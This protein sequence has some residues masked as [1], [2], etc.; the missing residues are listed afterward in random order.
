MTDDLDFEL[1]LHR[2]ADGVDMPRGDVGE[3]VSRA[4]R[5]TS[6]RRRALVA[7]ITVLVVAV[8]AT[9]VE[10][11]G[12]D[13]R[14]AGQSIALGAVSAHLGDTGIQWQRVNP[15]SALGF[16]TDP[17]GTSALYAL[18]TSPGQADTGAAPRVVW[19]SEDGVDWTAVGSSL[20]NDLY[21]SDL[22]SADQRIYAVGT[23][24]AT[25]S[26]TSG[27]A[28]SGAL[29]VGWSD[30]NA[31]TFAKHAL[32]LDLASIARY[33]TSVSMNQTQV[34]VG[35]H[36]AVVAATVIVDPDVAALLPSG[37][38][39]PNGWVITR[40]G[41]DLLGNGNAC[42]AGT[43][44][45]PKKV[46]LPTTTIA[47]D[48]AVGS[49]TETTSPAPSQ[50]E[51]AKKLRAEK[52]AVDALGNPAGNAS[53]GRVYRYSCYSADGSEHLTNPQA[54]RGVT[55]SFT[56]AQLG[57]D[58]DLLRAIRGEPFVFAAAGPGSTDFHRVDVAGIGGV[59]TMVLRADDDGFDLV[60]TSAAD[61]VSPKSESAK[62]V[63]LHSVDG[64][65]WTANDAAPQGI[66]W[67]SAVGSI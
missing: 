49:S 2:L 52:A 20:G 24:P 48:G 27:D 15:R 44:E 40:D 67:V 12:R 13:G 28:V 35:A 25:A 42:P 26:T 43:T 11:A 10:I 9:G 58:G 1:D 30:D 55:R 64:Q 32:P 63:V 5:R 45:V 62:L 51:L 65:A 37:V 47:P 4:A 61:G 8:A 33:A 54:T 38:T 3:V 66:D 21:L 60:A 6:H 41:V 29:L 7:G 23:G 19:R 17:T 50:A 22:A 39:A 56:W 16:S 53:N 46:D 31:K 14:D 57:V 18:S 36:G 34:A 59:G